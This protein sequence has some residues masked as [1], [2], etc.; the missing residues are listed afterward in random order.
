MRA[1]LIALALVTFSLTGEEEL[2]QRATAVFDRA[3]LSP[4]AAIPAAVLLRAAAIAVVPGAIREGGQYRGKGVM[5]ARGARPDAWS[6][7]AVFAFEGAIPLDLD[8]AAVDFILIAQ[9]RQGLDHLVRDG[10]LAAVSRPISAGAIGHS[11]PVRMDS[12]LVAYIQFDTYFAGVTI[13]DW[14]VRGL[15]ASNAAL[16]GRPYSTDDIVRGAGFFHLPQ[17]ARTWR[18]TIAGYFRQMS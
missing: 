10:L 5:S 8:A 7:P 9:T 1:A 17:P 14:A 11:S 15:T 16:Y 2:L 18:K 12:D 3:V 6:A 4:S 13:D